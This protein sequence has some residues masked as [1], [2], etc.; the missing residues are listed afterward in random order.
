MPLDTYTVP[1][2]YVKEGFYYSV[3]QFLK[4]KNHLFVSYARYY[5][6]N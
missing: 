1:I 5:Y 2:L 3:F 4:V 6:E